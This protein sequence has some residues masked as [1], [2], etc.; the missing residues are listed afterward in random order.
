MSVLVLITYLKKT[1]GKSK[2]ATVVIIHKIFQDCAHSTPN[3]AISICNPKM[4]IAVN[5]GIKIPT[6]EKTLVGFKKLS[7][8]AGVNG[9]ILL[10]VLELIK[11]RYYL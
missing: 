2:L 5:P 1:K 10:S 7:W 3:K 9:C 6:I 11:I 4:P 8:G